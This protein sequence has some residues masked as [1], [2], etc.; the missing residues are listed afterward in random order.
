[1]K[2][3][4]FNLAC[5]V[6]LL[7]FITVLGLCFVSYHKAV[8]LQHRSVSRPTPTR[9]VDGNWNVGVSWGSLVYS[10]RVSTVDYKTPAE[11][12]DQ[13]ATDE[14][15]RLVRLQW[16]DPMPMLL[17]RP[18]ARDIGIARFFFSNQPT[19]STRIVLV[20]CWLL[21]FLAAIP[22]A[23]WVTRWRRQR[24]ARRRI[25]EGLCP[26]CGYD[27]RGSPE[28]CPECGTAAGRELEVARAGEQVR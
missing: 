19:R 18:G 4:W 23:V 12:D 13:V 2:P 27:L 21:A 22:P 3:V 11:A 15:P 14:S 5:A 1:V 24:S 8:M 25:A 20:P 28:R 10:S 9:V 7:L 6:S 26:K 17:M 16:I